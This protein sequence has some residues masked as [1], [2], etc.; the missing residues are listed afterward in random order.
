VYIDSKDGILLD[1]VIKVY[2][3]YRTARPNESGYYARWGESE[4]VNPND[5]QFNLTARESRFGLEFKGPDLAFL[6]T[7]A[8]MEID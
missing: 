6:N 5:D 4:A 1:G 7:R 2:A 3:A 8:K